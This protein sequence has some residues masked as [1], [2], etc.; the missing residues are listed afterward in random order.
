MKEMMWLASTYHDLESKFIVFWGWMFQTK[1]YFSRLAL[2][3]RFHY[4]LARRMW[5]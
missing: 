5:Y 2:E 4:D 3:T 1:A